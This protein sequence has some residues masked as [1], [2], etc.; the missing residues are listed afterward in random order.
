MA[1]T[2]PYIQYRFDIYMD[3]YFTNIPSFAYLRSIGIGACGTTGKGSKKF[4]ATFTK[5]RSSKGNRLVWNTL[6][7]EVV[8]QVLA[9]LWMDN[10]YVLPL[11][12][13]HEVKGLENY[14]LC[15]RRCP[16]KTSTNA[17]VVR[18][19]FGDRHTRYLLI[20]IIINPTVQLFGCRQVNYLL[21]PVNWG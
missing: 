19:I 13:I 10:N 2:L 8:D 12:T 21:P 9:L 5:K 14:I 4:P 1:K 20:P 15:L 17:K 16:G 11:T 3:N 7:G 6:E 18:P